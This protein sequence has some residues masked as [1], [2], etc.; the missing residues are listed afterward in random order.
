MAGGQYAQLLVSNFAQAQADDRSR[1]VPSRDAR[2]ADV[3]SQ[4]VYDYA[5]PRPSRPKSTGQEEF[6][7]EV[8]ARFGLVPNFFKSAPD[9]PFVIR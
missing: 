8:A 1:P 6:E 2:V 3:R 9:A 5:F 7:R 4:R